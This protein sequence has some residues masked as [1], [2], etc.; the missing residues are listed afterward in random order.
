M[1]DVAVAERIKKAGLLHMS[2][3]EYMSPELIDDAIDGTLEVHSNI[4]LNDLV[5]QIEGDQSASS[6]K[7]GRAMGH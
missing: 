6:G 3:D 4:N 5:G 7:P 2:G 1:S